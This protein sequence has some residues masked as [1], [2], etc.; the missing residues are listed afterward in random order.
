MSKGNHTLSIHTQG[1]EEMVHRRKTQ[2][3]LIRLD[4]EE[5]DQKA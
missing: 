3:N 5:A 1:N 4:L 2:L